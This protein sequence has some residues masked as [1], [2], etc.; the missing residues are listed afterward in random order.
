MKKVYQVWVMSFVPTQKSKKTLCKLLQ[1]QY[2]AKVIRLCL[3]ALS[4]YRQFKKTQRS[5]D[6]KKISQFNRGPLRRYLTI[7]HRQVTHRFVAKA[8]A[9]KL[10]KIELAVAFRAIRFTVCMQE[11]TTEHIMQQHKVRL[12]QRAIVALRRYWKRTAIAD[13]QCILMQQLSAVLSAKMH[14]RAWR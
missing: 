3:K 7:W 1:Q 13:T 6:D 14:L 11:V 9:L 4:S 10:P 8:L 2:N 12:Q 5:Q